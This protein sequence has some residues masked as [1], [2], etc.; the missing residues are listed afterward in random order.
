[1]RVIVRLL[2]NLLVFNILCCFIVS[3]GISCC[4]SL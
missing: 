1:L 4:I 3:F 2:L